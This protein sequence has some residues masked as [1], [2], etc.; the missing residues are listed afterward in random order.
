[1]GTDWTFWVILLVALG[2]FAVLPQWMARR[3]QAKREEELEVGDQVMTIGGF[4]GTL[5]YI[6]FDDN[7]ARIRLAEGVE[8]EIL[9]GAISGKR[10]SPS[11]AAQED[12]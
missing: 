6:N 4:L 11:D 3:R 10:K 12:R 8:V 5:T 1:M 2:V 7:L 9:A